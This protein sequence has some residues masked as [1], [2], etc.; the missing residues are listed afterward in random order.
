MFPALIYDDFFEN[1][2]LVVDLANSLEYKPG[3][4]AWPG[5]DSTC[6]QPFSLSHYPV[7]A[8]DQQCPGSGCCDGCAFPDFSAYEEVENDQ[9]GDQGRAKG[10]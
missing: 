7:P 2:D 9:A 6:A 8:R 5:A 4:G 3:D 1:P 10:N